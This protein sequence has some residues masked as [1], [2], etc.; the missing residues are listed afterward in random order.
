M[1][2][3]AGILIALGAIL[4]LSLAADAITAHTILARV[5]FLVLLDV[6]LSPTAIEILAR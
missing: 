3:G 4:F 2:S 6:V 1:P 5:S